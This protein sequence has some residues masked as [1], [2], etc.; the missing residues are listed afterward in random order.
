M[1]TIQKEIAMSSKQGGAGMIHG[2]VYQ[3][4]WSLLRA[5]KMY[6]DTDLSDDLSRATQTTII[7]EPAGGG[8]DLREINASGRIIQQIKSGNHS[9]SLTTI[10]NDVLPDLYKAVDPG[11]QNDTFQFITDGWAG[12][13]QNVSAFFTSLRLPPCPEHEALLALDDSKHI[14]FRHGDAQAHPFGSQDTITARDL[15]SWI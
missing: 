14:R 7:L 10:V 5:A 4:L 9:W 6:V 13:W 3:L 12:D 11:Q 2:V 8:G 1:K 15:F